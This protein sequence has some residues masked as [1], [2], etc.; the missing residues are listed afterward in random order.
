MS[1]GMAQNQQPHYPQY[2]IYKIYIYS[3]ECGKG[4]QGCASALPQYTFI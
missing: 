1:L 3:Y 4:V 2:R